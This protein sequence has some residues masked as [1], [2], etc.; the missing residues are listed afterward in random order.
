[1]AK[2]FI[3]P[4]W[5][6]LRILPG[7]LQR[8]WFYCWDKADEAGVY[9]HDQEYLKLDL[10]LKEDVTIQDLGRLPDVEILPGDRILLKNFLLVNYTRLKPDYNPHKPA[11]RAIEKNGL[12][13]NSSLNQASLK[14]EEEGEDEEEDK[15]A[16]ER[17]PGKTIPINDDAIVPQMAKVF[18]EE[19]AGYPADKDTDY[20]Q[21]RE[22]AE[23]I[24]KDISG[25]KN[26]SDQKKRVDILLRWGDLVR[27]IKKD[28]HL[29]KYSL[30]QINKHYQSVVQSFNNASKSTNRQGHPHR[31]VVAEGVTTAGKF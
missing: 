20:P 26:L 30:T 10:K 25:S 17:G 14:L 16:K 1:M 12:T 3:E 22:L 19:N 5:K 18:Q 15:D 13:L 31:A 27:H 21:L 6:K 4:D 8:A 23:K 7:Y 24:G 11:F 29:C 2:R 9:H 28:S